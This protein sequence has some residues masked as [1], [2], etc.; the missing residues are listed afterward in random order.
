MKIGKR[1]Q[2]YVK[3][4]GFIT[5]EE[6][7][8][9][10]QGGYN[11]E[12]RGVFGDWVKVSEAY[13]VTKSDNR[14]LELK[15]GN[16]VTVSGDSDILTLVPN[17]YSL[18][19]LK[20]K[21]IKKSS[22]LVYGNQLVDE[23]NGCHLDDNELEDIVSILNNCNAYLEHTYEIFT[24]SANSD[25]ILR[26]FQRFVPDS[27]QDKITITEFTKWRNKTDLFKFRVPLK[28][29]DKITEV[30]DKYGIDMKT[31]NIPNCIFTADRDT[32]IRFY[33]IL[34]PLSFCNV[35]MTNSKIAKVGVVS[36]KN[37]NSI[38]NISN[39]LHTIGI[40]GIVRIAGVSKYKDIRITRVIYQ[41]NSDDCKY[42]MNIDD[43]QYFTGARN[44][45]YNNPSWARTIKDNDY[46]A[47]CKSIFY[48][49]CRNNGSNTYKFLE[50][51]Y[52]YQQPIKV[53]SL[54]EIE[55]DMV[56][57]VVDDYADI[58]GIFLK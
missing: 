2:I 44:M 27:R 47:S 48:T 28:Y 39:F 51:F 25:E 40:S 16:T 33:K 42:A 23:N 15:N 31:K 24:F 36:R 35:S 18:A 1:M 50:E 55:D 41:L 12:L 14:L 46:P 26:L 54:S 32:R 29:A 19:S 21:D 3:G 43:E 53:K 38:L 37:Y 13:T 56:E 57:F 6:A 10:V 11:L 4:I 45:V 5:A 17:G 20:V 52:K 49:Y 30:I 22:I 7:S 34:N 58:N 8:K 9:L